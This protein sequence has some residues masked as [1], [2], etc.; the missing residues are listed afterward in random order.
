VAEIAIDITNV[1][2]EM[3]KAIVRETSALPNRLNP[4]IMPI[5]IAPNTGSQIIALN[6]L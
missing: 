5:N 1:I 4:G 3:A 6:I 2:P